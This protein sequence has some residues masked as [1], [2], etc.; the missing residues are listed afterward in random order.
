MAHENAVRDVYQARS[1]GRAVTLSTVLPMIDRAV[2]DTWLTRSIIV[3]AR[4]G[5]IDVKVLPV[6][7][8]KI[9]RGPVLIIARS[10]LPI[11]VK[12]SLNGIAALWRCN[13]VWTSHF[14]GCMGS[15]DYSRPSP[16]NL[17]LV[18][19]TISSHFSLA[20]GEPESARM[21]DLN[22]T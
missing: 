9:W 3:P 1:D 20:R 16:Q 5:P 2:A 15:A 12:K 7:V 8:I 19:G 10:E 14:N 13:I 21:E 6:G 22:G 4:R 11:S 18:V 17:A